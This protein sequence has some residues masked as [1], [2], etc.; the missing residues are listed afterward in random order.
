[1]SQDV[2]VV[3]AGPAGSCTALNLARKGWR[4]LLVDREDFPRWKVCGGCLGPT[5][6][7][8][9]DDLGLAEVVR[10]TGAPSLR[11]M[12]LR[13]WESVARIPLKESL[14]L[15]RATLDRLLVSAAEDAGVTFRGGVSGMD[16]STDDDGVE[17]AVRAGGR[18][19]RL[20]AGVLI[21]ATGL[22][23][24][25]TL[26]GAR[27]EEEVRADA[28]IGVGAVFSRPPDD[29][30]EGELRMVV[31]GDG[32]V[33]LVVT[34]DGRLNVAAAL[35]PE[36][37]AATGP[38]EAVHRLLERSGTSVPEQAP[39]EGWR[40]TPALTRK[41]EEPAVRRVFRVGDS[42]GYVEP[43]T[44]EGMGWA[45]SS[46]VAVSRH[47]ETALGGR[48]DEAA[49]GWTVDHERIVDRRQRTCRLL[50]SGLR[51]P[52]LVQAVV[53]LLGTAPII[54]EPL[55]SLTSGVPRDL[56]RSASPPDGVAL[57]GPSAGTPSGSSRP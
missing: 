37:V 39:V 42:A 53:G 51:R 57:S 44:G 48:P 22:G 49:R 2:V 40:G 21:D 38:G 28:R 56:H 34:E 20:R 5:A 17:L 52:R 46:G 9:L 4:V 33:G 18:M 15:S 50:A 41:V 19:E 43:F 12:E 24:G 13:A 55:V 29:L 25:L 1:M 11:A 32:Y 26:D 3:G 27:P 6:L 31:D 7:A 45:I 30:D 35:D 36:A 54:A 23:R 10:D 47:V 16:V 8:L 14:A